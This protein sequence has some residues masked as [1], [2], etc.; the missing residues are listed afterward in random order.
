MKKLL[1]T[2]CAVTVAAS[3]FAQGT[4]VFNNRIAGTL[5]THVY[6]GGSAQVSGNGANDL[7]AGTMDW[8][9]YTPAAAGFM[10]ALIVN[11]G[12]SQAFAT[13]DTGGN[14]AALRT[15]AAAGFWSGATATLPGVALNAASANLAVFAWDNTSGNYSDATAAWNAWKAQTIHGGESPT[16]T[17]SA[18]GGDLNTPPALAGLQSFNVITSVPEPSTLALAGLGAA[19]MLIFRRRK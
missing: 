10:A 16:F 12:A 14:A 6:V 4:V 1:L 5:I 7:P 2:A 18:I 15:G 11:P 17:V 8:S 13:L 19:A 3:V 9:A